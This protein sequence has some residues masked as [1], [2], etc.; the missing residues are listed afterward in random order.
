[1]ECDI[2]DNGKGETNRCEERNWGQEEKGGGGGEERAIYWEN[3]A[4]NINIKDE[5]ERK[6]NYKKTRVDSDR[7]WL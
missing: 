1:M 6:K 5:E 4:D 3:W 2:E 7:A